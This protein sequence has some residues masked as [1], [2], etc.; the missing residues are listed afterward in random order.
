[1]SAVVVVGVLTAVPASSAADP[2]GPVEFGSSDWVQVSAGTHHACGIRTTGR[3]YCWGS[4]NFGQLGN[5]APTAL[6]P[7]PI[8]VAGGATNWTQVSAGG[9]HTC[10][11]RSTGRLFCWGFDGF[12]QLGNGPTAGEQ[13]TPVQV[14]G[15]F[16][17]WTQVSAGSVH[18]CGRRS[19][20]RLYCWGSD[21]FG[22]LGDGGTD[23]D[24]PAPTLVAGGATNW[25][26][27]SA[28]GQHTCALRSTRRLWCW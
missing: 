11:R 2:A 1:M 8:Q 23:A 25:T 21:T 19:T 6:Q 4:D 3:L 24:Q 22:Q 7:T 16:T 27:V 9:L 20:G 18:T 15:G 26:N 12:G 28:G 13:P 10:A 17:D 5:G 14:A